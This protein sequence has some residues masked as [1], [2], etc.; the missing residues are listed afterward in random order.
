MSFNLDQ[1]VSGAAAAVQPVQSVSQASTNAALLKGLLDV[2]KKPTGSSGPTQSDR[3]RKA[4]LGIFRDIQTD[5]AKGESQADVAQKY[6]IPLASLGLN[7]EEKVQAEK[8]LGSE[9]FTRPKT[10]TL[11]DARAE[12]FNKLPA[13]VRAGRIQE[14]MD[15]AAEK[16]IT[17]RE[18][19]A[20]MLAAETYQAFNMEVS[21]GV[22]QGNLDFRKGF[23]TRIQ[24]LDSLTSAISKGL[25]VE[26]GGQNFDL[27]TVRRLR[28]GFLALKAQPAYQ[29]PIGEAAQE[30]WQIME[31][32]ISAI[33]KLFLAIEDYDAK[34][35]TAEAKRL[36]GVLALSGDNPMA[37][38]AVN[39][40]EFMNKV[41]AKIAPDITKSL[42]ETTEVL[43]VD[44]STLDFDPVVLELMGVAPSGNQTGEVPEGGFE[45]PPSPFP[46]S[47][48]EDYNAMSNRKKGK[49]RVY[50]T[51]AI[52]ALD[53]VD[54]TTPDAVNAYA[55]SVT[56][57]SFDLTQNER[58]SSKTFDVLF[59]NSNIARLNKL[60]AAGGESGRI[61]AQLRA[62]MGAALVHNQTR[63]GILA[64][65]KVD[66]IPNI[67]ID[68]TTNKFTITDTSSRLM[69]EIAAVADVYYGGDFEALWKEGSSARL[70]LRDR[71]AA[72]GTVSPDS[73]EYERFLAATNVLDTSLWRGMAGQ[74]AKVKGIPQRLQQFKD[75]AKRM[76]IALPEEQ[77]AQDA[78]EAVEGSITQT[79][80]E[81]LGTQTNPYTLGGENADEAE[82]DAAFDALPAGAF[83]INPAD[84]R[85]L[86]KKG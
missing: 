28:D 83:F 9:V 49:T 45:V 72:Q 74:Y 67:G 3:D 1:N 64:A 79:P 53:S 65:G 27:E 77:V 20:A 51:S 18:D 6:S 57:L 15:L 68:P 37:V 40:P 76:Q 52:T 54:L 55:S 24:V 69:Q 36:M 32:R 35:A 71:L 26:T 58:H 66:T 10:K 21:S 42:A 61:A 70:K 14:E 85:L 44:H 4:K 84:G 8:L 86:Q 22:I 43:T 60:Q 2:A 47:L 63:Y 46:E 38:L 39:S 13:V 59:S 31:Q 62:Q 30:Q 50:H 29:K 80:L 48:S 34:A 19:Q 16:G 17:L 82:T 41:A 81:D 23:D 5:L 25:Q 73:P 75:V 12:E 33:D 7:P 56:A 11:S 78:V